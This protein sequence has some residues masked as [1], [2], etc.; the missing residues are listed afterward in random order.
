MKGNRKE[1]GEEPFSCSRCNFKSMWRSAVYNHIRHV[2]EKDPNKPLLKCELCD[3][4]TKR[5]HHMTRHKNVHKKEATH[6]C[7]NCD[8]RF[9][10]M[11]GLNRHMICLHSEGP[12]MKCDECDYTSILLYDVKRHFDIMHKPSQ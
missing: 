11:R 6:T 1:D 4:S 2:H 5:P 10:S 3:Y 7:P 8:K 12:A 9:K